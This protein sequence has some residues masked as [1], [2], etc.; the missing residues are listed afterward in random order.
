[1]LCLDDPGLP[2]Y[3]TGGGDGGND[4][5]SE[6]GGGSGGDQCT[7]PTFDGRNQIILNENFP[8]PSFVFDFKDCTWYSFGSQNNGKVVQVARYNGAKDDWELLDDDPLTG[9]GSWGMDLN[10]VSP[11]VYWVGNKWAMYYSARVDNQEG[12][13]CVGVALSDSIRGPYQPRSEPIACHFD[14]GGAIDPSA[15]YDPGSNTRWVVYKIDG[16]RLCGDTLIMLQ[17][18]RQ[19]L[20]LRESVLPLR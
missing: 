17:Q 4:D 15:F 7:K 20:N 18:V 2:A 11:D 19:A 8:D 1:M 5:G 12:K 6:D 16:N 3:S 10:V 14:L 13:R 9:A